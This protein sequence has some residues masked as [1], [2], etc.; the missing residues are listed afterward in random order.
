MCL[1]EGQTAKKEMLCSLVV[2]CAMS[3]QRLLSLDRVKVA[4]QIVACAQLVMNWLVDQPSLQW[5][6]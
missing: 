3:T 1:H 2:T 6:C 5:N 4:G